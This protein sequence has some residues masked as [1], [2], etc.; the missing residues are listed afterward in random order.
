MRKA[1]APMTEEDIDH[2]V[3]MLK[4]VLPFPDAHD[5][6]DEILGFF[7]G[8]CKRALSQVK[9]VPSKEIRALTD[10]NNVFWFKSS[11]PIRANS[12][13]EWTHV[14]V[15][16]FS[17]A[18]DALTTV[19]SLKEAVRRGRYPDDFCVWAQG[20]VDELRI[21]LKLMRLCE[22]E[23]QTTQ[24]GIVGSSAGRKSGQARREATVERNKLMKK[25]AL[26]LLE[27]GVATPHS[28]AERL[29]GKDFPG[30]KLTTSK[31]VRSILQKEGVLPPLKKRR[32]RR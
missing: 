2:C 4:E 15:D 19:L 5:R 20:E 7:E 24:S 16:L 26:E 32:K 28:L 22:L 18:T 21:R 14:E 12:E 30:K 27:S 17:R 10:A 8:E 13:G 29:K 6:A 1:T 11:Y 3:R 31:Q 23:G 25:R 9:G